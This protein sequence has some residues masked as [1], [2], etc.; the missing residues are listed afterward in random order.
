MSSVEDAGKVGLPIVIWASDFDENSGG[1][2]V[3]HTLAH[4]L[5]QAGQDAFV[6]NARSQKIAMRRRKLGTRLFALYQWNRRRRARRRGDDE[7]RYSGKVVCHP[8]MPVPTYETPWK[9][10]CIAV[11][12]EIIAGNPLGADHVVRWLLHRPGFHASNVSFGADELTFFY[13]PAFAEGLGN[14]PAENL[15]QV[16]W[17]RTDVYQ[18]LRLAERQGT[19]R[20]VR[21]GGDTFTPEIAMGDAAPL[22]DG[23]KHEEIAEVFNRC[24]YFY[25]HDPYTM[26]LYYAALCGCIPVVV[27]QPGL[28]AETWRAGF[29]LKRGVAYGDREIPFAVETREGLLEDMA[30]AQ[31]RE[32]HGVCDFIRKIKLQYGC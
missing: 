16:R 5:R 9:T 26:Y 12:P 8:T 14:V 6:W 7:Q 3:L 18:D 32:M 28:E 27:P 24:T 10:N 25:S 13:Q 21:K 11:Y 31:A 4:R 15:L 22:L 20:M 2:I 29:E 1:S 17:L 23:L 30:A 19:C